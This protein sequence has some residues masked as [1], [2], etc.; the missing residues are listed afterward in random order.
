MSDIW[1]PKIIRKRNNSLPDH[2]LRFFHKILTSVENDEKKANYNWKN[3]NILRKD[4]IIE[5]STKNKIVQIPDKIG[6]GSI[7]FK[8]S[9]SKTKNFL[10]N[11]RHA[12]AHNYIEVTKN[13]VIRIAL[14]S[15]NKKHIKLACQLPF[16]DL[17]K[18]IDKL[19][20]SKSNKTQK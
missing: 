6:M 13:D 9:N 20:N 10:K 5:S 3:L 2:V 18:V 19:Q 16:S 7:Y 12:F 15:K 17:E 11:L 8:E 14:P 4:L 1:R